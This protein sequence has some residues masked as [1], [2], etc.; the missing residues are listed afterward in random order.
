MDEALFPTSLGSGLD[1]P[2][3]V[4][5]QFCRQ[6][7]A[8]LVFFVYDFQSFAAACRYLSETCGEC[9]WCRHP[10]LSMVYSKQFAGAQQISS[11]S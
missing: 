11:M 4:A 1:K 10:W 5:V 3:A 6:S 7:S 9:P 8:K 2:V